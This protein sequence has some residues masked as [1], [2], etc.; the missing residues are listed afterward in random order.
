MQLG[1][2]NR[3][4]ARRTLSIS[5]A[6]RARPFASHS[7][8]PALMTQIAGTFLLMQSSTAART[9]S[10][11]TTIIARSTAPGMS[12]TRRYAGSPPISGATGCTGTIVPVNPATIRLL[13]ISDP[14]LPRVRL[15]PITATTRGSKNAR[16][17][18]VAASCER[19][20]ACSTKSS[21]SAR[22]NATWHTPPSRLDVSAR[23]EL[24]NTSSMRRLSPS[25]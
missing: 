25:T 21:V 3:Q 14:I 6:S 1:P 11:G 7:L 19:V 12:V 17:D 15:A 13:R 10:A 4:P 24:R 23:P 18:A 9:S 2:I 5:I 20:A 8:K 16:I 22:D